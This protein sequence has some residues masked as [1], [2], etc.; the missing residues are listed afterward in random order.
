[1]TRNHPTIILLLVCAALLTGCA[2]TRPNDQRV[3]QSIDSIDPNEKTNRKFYNFTDAVDRN[4]SGAGCGRL[5]YAGSVA[6]IAIT[7]PSL[8]WVLLTNGRG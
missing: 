8:L 3:D 2:T 6:S 1:M 7:G 5:F 4:I